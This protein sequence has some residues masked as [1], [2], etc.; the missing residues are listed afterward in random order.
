MCVDTERRGDGVYGYR[1]KRGRCV[2]IPCVEGKECVDTV[3]R[4]EEVCGYRA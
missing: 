1:V 3:R 2:W 4:G